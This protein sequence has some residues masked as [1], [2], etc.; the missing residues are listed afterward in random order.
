M[1]VL[2]GNAYGHGAV[3]IGRAALKGGAAWLAVARV[4]EA[5]A[6]RCAEITAPVLVLGTPPYAQVDTA[7]A[8][9]ITLPL[10]NFEAAEVYSQRAKALGRPIQVHLKVDTGMGRLGVLPHEILPLAQKARELGGID[11][12]GIFSHFANAGDENDPLTDVQIRN[13]QTALSALETAGLRPRWAH[14][15]NTPALLSLPEARFDMVRGAEAHLGLNPFS[16][17]ELTEPLMPALTAWKAR[18]ISCKML[19]ACWSIGYG[20]AYT[21]QTDEMIG[22]ISAGFGDGIR[23]VPHN[24]VLIEGLRVPVVGATCMDAVM[25]KLPR[26]FP[27]DSVVTLLGTSGTETITL[28]DIANRYHTVHV[29]VLSGITARVPRVYYRD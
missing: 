6:L 26:A 23:R 5:M 28:E 4:D 1:A 7:I 27:L 18:L 17:R 29:D 25:V 15:S 22:V 13:F 14:L 20:S 12:T 2:K 16:F 8:N 10:A 24:E 3:E 19:P 21:L 9:T 11:I